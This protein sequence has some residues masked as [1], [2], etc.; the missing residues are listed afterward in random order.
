VKRLLIIGAGYVGAELVRQAKAQGWKVFAITKSG[1]DGT[2]EADVSCFKSVEKLY[3]AI[4]LVDVIVHC[5]SSGRGGSR[6]YQAV[7]VEGVQNLTQIFKGTPIIFTSSTS[8]YAQTEGEVVNEQSIT[9]PM[10][11]TGRLLLSAEQHVI[12]QNGVVA[13]LAG[14][15]GP[16]RS[17]VLKKMLN[18]TA[19][20]EQ[21][22]HKFINQIHRD[23]AASALLFLAEGCA[24]GLYARE[25]FNVSDSHPVL[26]INLYKGLAQIFAMD[27]PPTGPKRVNS[28]RGWSHK[29]V[30]NLKLKQAGWK[31]EYD[32]FLNVAAQLK[33]TINLTK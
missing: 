21:D 14:I 4:G 16:S 7:F 26:Q 29:A 32:D 6:A 22:G 23:D 27:L 1:E 30:S 19:V 8:V 20:I 24:R 33:E 28:K 3:E 10:R 5:A 15:Y 17:M 2:I 13:R 9:K 25:I 18:K 12:E 11:E 31:P